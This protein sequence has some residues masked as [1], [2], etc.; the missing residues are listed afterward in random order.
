MRSG[1]GYDEKPYFSHT[2]FIKRGSKTVTMMVHIESRSAR[3]PINITL[4]LT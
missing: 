3:G 4:L 1:A 2:A